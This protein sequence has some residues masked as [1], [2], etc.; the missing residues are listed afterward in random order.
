MWWLLALPLALWPRCHWYT[1][2][3]ATIV[4]FLLLGVENIGVQI[5]QPFDVLPLNTL[6]GACERN[7]ADFMAIAPEA[8]KFVDAAAARA[9]ARAAAA[10]AAAG[11]GRGDD[12]DAGG[13]KV[14]GA[15]GGRQA[16]ESCAVHADAGGC[17]GVPGGYS[18]NSGSV[19][20]VCGGGEDR[21]GG[22]CGIRRSLSWNGPV[23]LIQVDPASPR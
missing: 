20:G 17:D 13:G 19:G 16:Q 3:I 10:D 7:V 6:C 15:A 4:A 12:S 1:P 14:P 8:A 23:Q 21:E 2:A 5:E 18:I 22:S 9:A 11:S